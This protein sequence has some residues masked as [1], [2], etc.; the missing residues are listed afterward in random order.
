MHYV[1]L[2]QKNGGGAWPTLFRHLWLALCRNSA[3][4]G[5]GGQNGWLAKGNVTYLLTGPARNKGIFTSEPYS[6][7]LISLAI[8]LHCSLET[9]KNN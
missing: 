9:D 3:Q 1:P 8:S 4:G 7:Q 2:V 6:L 5:R